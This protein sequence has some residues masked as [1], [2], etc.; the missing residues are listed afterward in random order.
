[1]S[2]SEI[3]P[4]IL[5]NIWVGTLVCPPNEIAQT[6]EGNDMDQ[7]T[8][9]D[10]TTATAIGAILK[11]LLA[12]CPSPL[13]PRM[14]DYEGGQI[15]S[16]TGRSRRRPATTPGRRGRRDGGRYDESGPSVRGSL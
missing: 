8:E 14:D 5:G 10:M 6:D 9:P 3:P 1:M 15:S 16:S 4:S 12:L 13:R 7:G 2:G 11:T